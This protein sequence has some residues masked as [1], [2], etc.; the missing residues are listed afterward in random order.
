MA[1]T[2]ITPA[3]GAMTGGTPITIAGRGFESG[4]TVMLGGITTEATVS[5]D[6]RIVAETP[7]HA[8]GPVDL[9]VTNSD[10]RKARLDGGFTY[11]GIP[12]WP[13]PTVTAISETR[14]SIDGG[15]PI[16]I[17]GTG[18]LPGA[19]VTFGGVPAYLGVLRTAFLFEG[20]LYLQTPPHSAGPVPVVVTNPDGQSATV[21]DGYTY[22][23]P[24]TIDYNGEW[25]GGTGLDWQTPVRFT[26][27]DNIVVSIS[28]GNV[29]V[30]MPALLP[31]VSDGEFSVVNGGIVI[32]TGR[33]VTDTF[34]RGTINTG[35]CGQD[36]WVANKTNGTK[37]EDLRGVR[38]SEV[39]G[40]RPPIGPPGS[41]E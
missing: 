30:P 35:P 37:G 7:A 2:T 9:V 3:I 31:T 34:A 28:C 22:I 17:S 1:V 23:P 13:A 5:S 41:R 40:P 36:Q 20:S 39:T 11:V 25:D 14:G 4:A 8:V 29:V 15:A 16:V 27:R 19:V 26:I 10:G 32:M 6:T 21:P 12:P 24:G 18:F 33:I 38:R